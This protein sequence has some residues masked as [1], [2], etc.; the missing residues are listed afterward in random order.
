MRPVAGHRSVT[1][2]SHPAGRR[3]GRKQHQQNKTAH[4]RLTAPTLLLRYSPCYGANSE[5]SMV[6][7]QAN[8]ATIPF[9]GEHPCTDHAMGLATSRVRRR[10]AV[11]DRT[12]RTPETKNPRWR[13]G[14]FRR[15]C[16]DVTE[17]RRLTRTRHQSPKGRRYGT[18]GQSSVQA[19]FMWMGG[20]CWRHAATCHT[21]ERHKACPPG[22]PTP[23]RTSPAIA[24][25]DHAIL[26]SRT[27]AQTRLPSA[28]ST[29]PSPLTGSRSECLTP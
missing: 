20:A 19:F 23:P 24:R 4:K 15:W 6:G 10:R 17:G 2:P 11:G 13:H 28:S 18:S 3:L 29:T 5:D 12:I 22:R 14:F 27:P 7:D 8:A 25:S 16:C 1:L 26:L 9:V 21:S